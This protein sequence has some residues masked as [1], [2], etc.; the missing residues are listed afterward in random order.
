M[1]KHWISLLFVW[2]LAFPLSLSAQSFGRTKVNYHEFPFKVLET[3]HFEIYHYQPDSLWMSVW[4]NSVED[5]YLLHQKILRD[6]FK[7]KNP[8]ILYANH[9]DFQQ[10]RTI[11][12]AVSVG[13]GGV[14][15]ALKNRVVIPFAM[16]NQQ[17]HHVLGHEL[18]HA[19]QYDM[20]IRGD[21]TN[22][23]N[24]QYLPL[25][26]VEG[27]AEYLSIGRADAQTA[28]WMRD[29]MLCDSFPDFKK[30]DN[31]S[32]YFPYRY[33]Q[34]FWAYITG[35]YGDRILQPL[36]MATA[37][38]SFK[39]AV[40]TI[41]HTKEKELSEQWRTDLKAYYG[42]ILAGR[43]ETPPG[44]KLIDKENAGEM[45]VSPAL[46]PNGRYLVF[47]TEKDLFSV[48]LYLADAR[49]GKIMN[50]VASAAKDRQID[51]FQ[52]IESSGAW[53]PDSRRFALVAFSKGRNILVIKEVLT[54]KTIE[55]FPIKDVPALSNPAWSPDGKFIAF[56]GLVNGQVDLYAVELATKKTIQLTNDRYSELHPAWSKDGK[57][58]VFSTDE[59]SYEHGRING[60]WT[61]NL[62][63][64]DIASGTIQNLNVFL[65]ANNF[66]PGF[67][68]N[69]DIIFL[70]DRDG[71]RNIYR[72]EIST[73][74]IYQLTDLLTGV[75][76]ITAYAPAI[77]VGA[78]GKELAYTHYYHK[79]YLIYT[80]EIDQLLS[81]EVDPTDVNQTAA[82]IFPMKE[83][84]Q[85]VV[86]GNMNKLDALPALPDTATEQKP[87][88]P[89]F[90]LDYVGGGGGVGVGT[91][92]T[93][94]TMGYGSGG[95]ELLF[96]D[97]LGYNQLYS[98][99]YLNGEIYDFAGIVAYM[100]QKKRLPWGVSIL[101]YPY[102]SARSYFPE[103]VDIGGGYQAIKYTYDLIRM[104]EDRVDVFAYWPFSTN[105]RIE[106][107]G[108]M[109]RYSYRVD[110]YE[111][112]YD[113]AGYLFYMD[114]S[115]L[116][117]PPGF[118]LFNIGTSL[119]GDKS[120]FGLASPMDGHRFRIGVDQY[121]G[122]WIFRNVTVDLRKYYWVR[123]VSF[124][125]RFIYFGRLGR[126]ADQLYP[127]YVGDPYLVRGY[128][129]KYDHI[130][131]MGL[132]YDQLSGSQIAV[133]NAEVRLP[134][135]GPE[136]IAMIKSRLLFSELAL[137][138]D[139]GAAWYS[140]NDFKDTA[141]GETVIPHELI[142]SA[143]FSWR[144]NLFG[145]LVLEPYYAV[146]LRKER[147]GIWGLNLLMG[148]W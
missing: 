51:D 72:Y 122:E 6:T 125:L 7:E 53:S 11:S 87:Y 119:V 143:G 105:L 97:M 47:F 115:K 2:V 64:L 61:F 35:K 79:E 107:G 25:W 31:Y 128:G 90:K 21:S 102:R 88:R 40:D 140:L 85:D 108:A 117:A 134:F 26:M 1:K 50:K 106:A 126:D 137:F 104:F 32:E 145:A 118:N 132:D 59:W 131:G 112:Y 41:F 20:V 16:T 57:N 67:D 103:I 98:G 34:L 68:A 14:T 127:M 120:Y 48:N 24:L 33:G 39:N 92:A 43:K 60:K 4:A 100:N 135:T 70:S 58:I 78:R 3:P 37:K 13:T 65:G 56:T 45:N 73:G 138:F 147:T 114:R 36:F 93:Y 91:G 54:G 28:M 38:Y 29:A 69:D 66:N 8:I 22:L 96:G 82:I 84:L 15:E 52:F 12:S 124:G 109:A 101:H 76:G 86:L 116:D 144:V 136:Q 23:N 146:P 110:R 111:D 141:G 95:V 30:M 9:A 142:S 74:K 123:P 81:R 44:R 75:S 94:G 129:Y 27:M 46:S 62:A 5:W 42:Q 89:K 77:S 99:L 55:S 19:F 18:V 17:T 133:A 130:L 83:G 121:F 80:A 113:L 148:G 71:F 10:T 139:S 49:T 63:I